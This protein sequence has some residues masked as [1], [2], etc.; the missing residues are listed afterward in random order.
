MLLVS[1]AITVSPF[2]LKLLFDAE[3]I[4]ALNQHGVVRAFHQLKVERAVGPDV[5]AGHFNAVVECR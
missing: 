5:L 2:K 1:S 4:G 3:K